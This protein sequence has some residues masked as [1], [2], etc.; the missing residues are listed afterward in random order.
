M[1]TSEDEVISGMRYRIILDCTMG[2]EP[3][4]YD[5]NSETYAVLIAAWREL[6]RQRGERIEFVEFFVQL[7]RAVLPEVDRDK[8]ERSTRDGGD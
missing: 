1:L 7:L 5:L 3:L 4:T 2:G 8:C 6:E